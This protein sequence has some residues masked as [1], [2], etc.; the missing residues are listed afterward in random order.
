M[1]ATF[2]FFVLPAGR[3]GSSGRPSNASKLLSMLTIDLRPYRRFGF[4]SS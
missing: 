2:A 4:L 1:G 3:L